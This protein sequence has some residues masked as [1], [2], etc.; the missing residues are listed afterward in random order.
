MVPAEPENYYLVE[1]RDEFSM[2]FDREQVSM[3][4]TECNKVGTSHYAFRN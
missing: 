4:G 1:R 3:D 2:L